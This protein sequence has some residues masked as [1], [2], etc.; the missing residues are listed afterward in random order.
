MAWLVL[1]LAV[2]RTFKQMK[3]SRIILEYFEKHRVV[4]DLINLARVCGLC[5]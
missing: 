5:M 1:S 4:S 3:R 2:V